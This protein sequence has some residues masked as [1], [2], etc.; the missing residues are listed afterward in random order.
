MKD[1]QNSSEEERYIQTKKSIISNLKSQKEIENQ[2]LMTV[3]NLL[4]YWINE[5][6]KTKSRDRER[7]NKLME[8]I[9]TERGT[10]KKIGDDINRLNERIDQT[11][12]N[13]DKIKGMV[14]SLREES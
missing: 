10:I 14:S 7:H 13:L 1:K 11:E 12:K 8:L 3:D 5:L 4:G 2:Y 9:N 6:G